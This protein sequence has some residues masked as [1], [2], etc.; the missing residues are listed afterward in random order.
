MTTKT[1]QIKAD[2]A[3]AVAEEMI[4]TKRTPWD[5]GLLNGSFNAR[6]WGTEKAYRGIN[7]LILAFFGTS[8]TA[9]YMTFLQAKAAHGKVK[10]GAKSLPVVFGMY[11]NFEEKREAEDGDDP[12]VCGFVL[13]RYCVF[14][15]QAVEGVEPKRE[16]KTANNEKREDIEEAVKRFF[17]ATGLSIEEQPGTA[18]YNMLNHS[19]HIAPI[20]LYKNT[21]TYYS[22]LFHEMAHST[23]SALSRKMEGNFGSKTY[24]AEE[25]CAEFT[26]A[27]LCSMFGIKA[28]KENSAVYIATW[29]QKIKENPDW[30]IRGA[31]DAE[32]A[33]D[34]ILEKM[35][36]SKEK[37]A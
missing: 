18:A 15:V 30:L 19:I 5:S 34:Y 16:I 17:E 4:K 12:D 9:E 32:K 26:A 31:N 25:V 1:Q 23:G 2:I 10:K 20:R 13:K 8:E 29:A 3:A 28:T 36:I 27:I 37:A 7:R 6:N 33:V 22:T 35:G 11:W 24:S 21:D 14:P